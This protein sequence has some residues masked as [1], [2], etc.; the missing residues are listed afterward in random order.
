MWC[1]EIG[2]GGAKAYLSIL[3]P[4]N[5][6][7]R[8]R[9]DAVFFVSSTLCWRLPTLALRLPSALE[10]LTAVFGMRT[11]VPPPTKHQHRTLES[12]LLLVDLNNDIQN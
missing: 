12:I 3:P 9:S 11:G 6:K 4:R 5:K 2:H 8:I 1:L 10:G 7:H